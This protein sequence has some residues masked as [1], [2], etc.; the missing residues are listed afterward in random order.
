[1]RR[2]LALAALALVAGGA[3]QE[4][5]AQG[6]GPSTGGAVALEHARRMLGHQMRVLMIG[7][8]P[9]DEDTEVLTILA[10][11]HGA[12]VAYLSLTRGEG[13]QNLIGPELGE[14]LGLIRSGELLAA[15][16]L[17]GA[18]QYFSRAYDFGF[19][20]TVD[21]AW[22]FWPRDS[23]LKDVVRV[24]RK[25][26]PQVV[27]SVF[28][29]SPRDGHGQHQAAGW[30]AR[31]AF[32]VAGDPA[33]F[34]ELSGE[35][36][37]APHTPLKLYQGARFDPSAPA[38]I[39]DGGALDP[40]VGQSFRQIAMRSRSQHRSQDQGVLQEV[41]PSLA[42]LTLVEDRT[43]AGEALWAGIDTAAVPGDPDQ[44]RH[45]ARVGAIEAGL[46]F[47]AILADD[48]VVRGQRVG[49]RLSAWNAGPRAVSVRMG[50]AVAAGEDWQPSGDCLGEVHRVEPNRV[51]HCEVNLRVA[52][53]ARSSIPYFLEWPREGAMY[54]WAGAPRDRGEAF[55]PAAVTATFTAVTV[56]GDTIPAVVAATFRARDQAWGEVRRPVHVVPR[57]SIGLEPLAGVWPLGRGGR[58]LG[59]S[60]RHGARD[61]TSG[62]VTLELPAGWTA[63]P[64]QRFLL[65]REG[66]VLRLAFAVRPPAGATAGR[67]EVRAVARTDSGERFDLGVE[68]VDYPHVTA[69]LLPRPAVAVVQLA[70]VA[71]PRV[72]RVG[73]IRGAAD[74]VPEVLREVGLPVDL[75]DRAALAQGDLSR[76]EVIVV[77]SRAFETDTALV[78]HHGRL[79]DWVRGGGRLVVQYQQQ[80]WFG[81][82]FAPLP[83]SLAARGHDRVTDETA[84]VRILR[85][86][87]PP[88]SG[89]NAIGPRDWDGWVQERGLYFATTWA[90]GWTPFL[91]MNDPGEPPLQGALLATAV[92]SGTYVYTG[93]SFFRQL[94][95]A[96]P[97]ALRLFLNLL[98][99]RHR[100]PTP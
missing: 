19:S 47:D 100:A 63:S 32:R 37:L 14:G 94:P 11:G 49:L 44:A 36:G 28:S 60:L 58:E 2:H 18:R 98:E 52:E 17:D 40:V 66:E 43:G 83:V 38:A 70:E 61:T 8:H 25:F 68:V 4:V 82:G 39:L 31:E 55:G 77:G 76:Y 30:A 91:E 65:R 85:D 88:F 57:V 64:P 97:G 7:A 9:D 54:R 48:Q 73:Y 5:P 46:V 72:S 27:V 90:P 75:L 12:E 42:R 26:R 34:P 95:A 24:I 3:V 41:G 69:R 21:E 45:R 67:H 74:R 84:T 96:V 29:G 13:G 53:G 35:E 93:L 6:A 89:P 78:E 16:S 92:G 79:L 20:K 59:V 22:R 1:L 51:V 80:A 86:G 15:R 62:T 50:V 81:G 56:G 33:A 23:V 99:Y 71:L 10:R 87:G